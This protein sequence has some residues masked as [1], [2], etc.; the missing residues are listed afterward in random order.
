MVEPSEGSGDFLYLGN[1]YLIRDGIS[2]NGLYGITQKLVTIFDA[3]IFDKDPLRLPLRWGVKDSVDLQ[4]I[5]I[6]ID[7]IIL[8]VAQ[9]DS[10]SADI[11]NKLCYSPWC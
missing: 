9:I 6:D 2:L 7:A 8:H 4:T 11:S 1:G 10:I 3:L 5:V